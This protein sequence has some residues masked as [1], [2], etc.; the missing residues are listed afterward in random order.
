[1]KVTVAHLAALL[2]CVS[3]AQSGPVTLDV[4]GEFVQP[5][6]GIH[7]PVVVGD[8]VRS[9][10]STYDADTSNISVAYN[11]TSDSL[12]I[13]ATLYVYPA[14]RP[15]NP[16]EFRA[17]FDEVCATMRD[18]HPGYRHQMY[19]PVSVLAGGK[20][21][22]GLGYS[23]V[24]DREMNGRTI[25]SSTYVLLFS[26]GP[27]FYKGRFTAYGGNAQAVASQIR[28]VVD[29]VGAWSVGD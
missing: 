24:E 8:F 25:T 2:L 1:M 22:E 5:R 15:P 3:I 10:V 12:A 20:R 29:S 28:A 26:R 13:V 7:F 11:M 19:Y 17:H 27:W 18:M 14:P 21:R 9:T 23:F 6:T 4:A 16:R